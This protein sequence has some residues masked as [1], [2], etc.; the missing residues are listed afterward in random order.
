M[1]NENLKTRVGIL[2]ELEQQGVSKE[3][4]LSLK[5]NLSSLLIPISGNVG[6]FYNSCKSS[7]NQHKR[8][9]LLV[10][11]MNMKSSS[12]SSAYNHIPLDSHTQITR[13]WLENRSLNLDSVTCC[14]THM[15][16]RSGAESVSA[17]ST[18]PDEICYYSES[19]TPLRSS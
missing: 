8:A 6:N 10:P 2:P 16:I 1:E 11:N 14:V 7:W 4:R 19:E 13:S 9:L 17:S 3:V 15:N 5:I 18:P 12:N